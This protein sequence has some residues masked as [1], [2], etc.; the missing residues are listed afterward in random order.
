MQGTEEGVQAR[1]NPQ[2]WTFSS[3][4]TEIV[5]LIMYGPT[6]SKIE[7]TIE[8]YTTYRATMYIEGRLTLTHRFEDP[9]ISWKHEVEGEYSFTPSKVPEVEI[10]IR[11]DMGQCFSRRSRRGPQQIESMAID[12]SV[13]PTQQDMDWFIDQEA[14]YIMFYR[15]GID[16]KELIT[17][18]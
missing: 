11:A 2:V 8:P 12:T 10:S 14:K 17:K 6:H 7:L 13:L 9:S 15:K 1:V 4:F 16:I 3:L 5:S 18:D